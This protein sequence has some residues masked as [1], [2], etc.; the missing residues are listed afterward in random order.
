MTTAVTKIQF[1]CPASFVVPSPD[2]SKYYLWSSREWCNHQSYSTCFIYICA[3]LDR[4]ILAFPIQLCGWER[5]IQTLI[6]EISTNPLNIISIRIL[7][8]IILLFCYFKLSHSFH[9]LDI[10]YGHIPY[11][12]RYNLFSPVPS[13]IFDPTVTSLVN[14]PVYVRVTVI[15]TVITDRHLGPRSK[16]RCVSMTTRPDSSILDLMI[17]N[18]VISY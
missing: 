12:R 17:I 7:L 5:Q 8:N 2:E 10:I 18:N 4:C 15:R 11:L 1:P 14:E 16:V 9:V 6:L 3:V 13:H